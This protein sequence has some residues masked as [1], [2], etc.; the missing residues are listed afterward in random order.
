[1][2]KSVQKKLV[3]ESVQETMKLT[4]AALTIKRKHVLCAKDNIKLGT[5]AVLEGRKKWKGWKYSGPQS[6]HTL[7][8]R[9]PR[10]APT[11]D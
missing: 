5:T 11:T 9:A 2:Q 4:N 3:V 8:V 7:Y 1:M 6:L 10:A